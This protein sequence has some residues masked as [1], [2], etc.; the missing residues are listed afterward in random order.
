MW[1][2]QAYVMLWKE[3]YLI[4][5]HLMGVNVSTFL[6]HTGNLHKKTK[7]KYNLQEIGEGQYRKK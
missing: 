7:L 1:R 4:K 5:L 3:G 2:K 6:C